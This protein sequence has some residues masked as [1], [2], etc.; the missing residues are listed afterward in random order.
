MKLAGNRKHMEKAEK[1]QELINGQPACLKYLVMRFGRCH[2][3]IS[4]AEAKPDRD[5]AAIS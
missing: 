3:Q 1:N 4:K 2:R 5:Q